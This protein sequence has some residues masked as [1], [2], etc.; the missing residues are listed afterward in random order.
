MTEPL[1]E[2]EPKEGK[3][4]KELRDLKPTKEIKGGVRNGGGGEKR[5]T[6]KTGEID[7][8]N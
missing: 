2:P 1:K 5:P 4:P 7:F 3:K 6:K 8:M